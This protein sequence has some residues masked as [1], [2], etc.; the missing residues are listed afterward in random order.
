VL[1]TQP[2]QTPLATSGTF[3]TRTE[4]ATKA[5]QQLAG[6]TADGIVGPATRQALTRAVA[7]RK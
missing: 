5:L 3:D 1:R 6:I 2:G 7:H 4:T